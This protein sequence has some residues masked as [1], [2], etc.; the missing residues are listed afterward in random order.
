MIT[1]PDLQTVHVDFQRDRWKRPLIIPPN[2]GKPVAYRRCTSYVD[3]IADKFK[4]QQWDKRQVAIGLAQ[5]DDLRLSVLAHL[6][7]P[8][9]G[10]EEWRAEIAESQE[11]EKRREDGARMGA[12]REAG[13]LRLL[14]AHHA[15]RDPGRPSGRSAPVCRGARARPGRAWSLRRGRPPSPRR[16]RPTPRPPSSRPR[17]P[18]RPAPAAAG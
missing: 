17:R 9:D 11:P 12:S 4:L 5:R 10:C 16:S 6:E 13:R 3:V 7:E 18:P 2:G 8:S 14:C 1:T 15:R